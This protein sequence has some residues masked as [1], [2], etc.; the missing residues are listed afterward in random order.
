[1]PATQAVCR[2]ASGAVRRL[3]RRAWCRVIRLS[4]GAASMACSHDLPRAKKAWDIP[5][6][7]QRVH[8]ECPQAHVD[9]L[10]SGSLPSSLEL[11]FEAA[12]ECCCSMERQSHCCRRSCRCFVLS[13]HRLSAVT[14]KVAGRSWLFTWESVCKQVTIVSNEQMRAPYVSKMDT[15]DI[16]T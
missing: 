9:A 16:L 10:E 8:A 6:A 3:I 2:W 5:R 4:K 1:M 13:A 7:L 12:P 14:L 11:F 15:T